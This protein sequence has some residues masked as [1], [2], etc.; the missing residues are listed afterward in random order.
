LFP[1]PAVALE[2]IGMDQFGKGGVMIEESQF[3]GKTGL[4]RIWN[5][6]HHSLAGLRTAC[7][8]ESAFR[9]ELL[10]AAIL[11]PLSFF[12]PATWSGRASMIASVL[13]MLIVELIN[14][15]IEAVVDRISLDRHPLSKQAK[16]IGSAAV[17]LTLLNVP[18]VWGC[19]L[20]DDFLP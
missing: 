19:V 18:I 20:L 13:L 9:Q 6:L 3:K 14:S 1:E 2:R 8:C 10:L 4:K 5:A 15:A 17:F 12:L 7:A 11:I 16:D